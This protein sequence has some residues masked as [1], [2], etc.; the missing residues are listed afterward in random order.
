MR[1]FFRVLAIAYLLK[2]VFRVLLPHGPAHVIDE[3]N[4]PV[5]S[6]VDKYN[7]SLRSKSGKLR[8]IYERLSKES[9]DPEAERL[10]KGP[11]SV[12]FD[13]DG[14]MYVLSKKGK[15]IRLTDFK[16]DPDPD[17][18]DTTAKCTEV[19]DLGV[20][21]PLGSSFAK[22]G[23]L[24]VADTLLGLI[25]VR[26]P[27]G[28]KP[29]VELVASRVKV[30]GKLSQI[31]FANDVVV[32]PKSGHVYFSDASDI[33][34]SQDSA[35]TWNA[36][37]A[38]KLDFMRGMRTG[39]LLRYTPNTGEI[40]V[41]ATDIWFASGVA[42]D[43]N[44]Q[45]VIVSE[46]FAARQLKYNLQGPNKGELEVMV[47]DLP[48]LPGKVD[49]SF[50]NGMCY[51]AIESGKPF[52]VSLLFLLPSFIERN[53]RTLIMMLPE[54]LLPKRVRYGAFVEIFPGW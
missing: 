36:L 19:V 6:D 17:S 12:V 14:T 16:D 32:G 37:H 31:L 51:A 47:K 49:C 39:R 11:G 26:F 38:S 20:G 45:F 15:L 5:F 48:G 8:K 1:N 44:E 25:R 46:T 42:V 29:V 33:A 34:P 41:L 4:R 18:I 22:D 54:F 10:M 43:K 40:D 52:V 13:S 9:D 27:N 21:N 24:Y 23:S 7:F 3:S 28:K 50:K 35:R 30:N 53:L 2:P